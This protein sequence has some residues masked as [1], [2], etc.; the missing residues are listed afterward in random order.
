MNL[1]K[2]TFDFEGGKVTITFLQNTFDVEEHIKNTLYS[3]EAQE[4]RRWARAMSKRVMNDPLTQEEY[5][6][7][8]EEEKQKRTE[9]A[10]AGVGLT[11]EDLARIHAINQRDERRLRGNFSEKCPT[12]RLLKDLVYYAQR[13]DGYLPAGF[14]DPVRRE[15]LNLAHFIRDISAECL[16]PALWSTSEE[17]PFPE[18]GI[19]LSGHP[20]APEAFFRLYKLTEELRDVSLVFMPEDPGY[21]EWAKTEEGSPYWEEGDPVYAM[22]SWPSALAYHHEYWADVKFEW[23]KE[24]DSTMTCSQAKE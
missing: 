18:G 17:L 7:L 4:T 8:T 11:D 9:D 13:D 10:K 2:K 20:R 22:F 5:D 15:L 6:S 19:P 16:N 23:H 12:T 21:E 3:Q 24:N 1:N 14:E